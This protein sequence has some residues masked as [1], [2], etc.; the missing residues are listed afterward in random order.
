MY[1]GEFDGNGDYMPDMYIGRIPA[2][3]SGSVS[4]VVNKILEYEKHIFADTKSFSIECTCFC[5]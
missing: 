4:S 3:D 5:G 1:Y 2:K